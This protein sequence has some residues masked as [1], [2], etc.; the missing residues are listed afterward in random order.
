MEKELSF[1]EWEQTVPERVRC[2][3][4]WESTY[5][6]LAMYLYDLAWCDGD[7][8]RKDFRGREIASQLIRST[9]GICA[10]VEE[11]YGR[12]L[13]TPDYVRIIRIALGE[14]RETQ[15]WYFRARHLL[16][17]ELLDRRL[18]LI[19]QIVALLIR[20]IGVHRKT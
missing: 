8:L 12:G 2:S 6:R 10:N 17:S 11:S 1:Q 16:P 13:G 4:L 9:G 5:Y 20:N 14:A 15:G 19:E 18:A 3:P 7:A